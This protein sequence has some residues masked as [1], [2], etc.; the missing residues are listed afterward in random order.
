MRKS[1]KDAIVRT[2]ARIAGA[3]IGF[4]IALKARGG[5]R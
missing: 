3:A 1:V 4:Y 5:L 2:A